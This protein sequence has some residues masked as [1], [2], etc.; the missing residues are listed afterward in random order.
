MPVATHTYLISFNSHKSP[1]HV[2]MLQSDQ[3][4][5]A[6]VPGSHSLSKLQRIWILLSLSLKLSQPPWN[7]LTHSADTHVLMAKRPEN[8]GWMHMQQ[9]MRSPCSRGEKPPWQQLCG[10]HS[11]ISHPSL[12]LPPLPPLKNHRLFPFTLRD[13]EVKFSPNWTCL[14]S[15]Y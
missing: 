13:R 2:S 1:C 11:I 12:L 10:F 5:T 7:T 3:G 9:Q 4:G 15:S 6:T 14:C 8:Q